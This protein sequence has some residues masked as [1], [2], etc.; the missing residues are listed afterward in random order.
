VTRQGA[1]AVVLTFARRGEQD[2]IR[3]A[4]DE[5]SRRAGAAAF[6]AVATPASLP[7]LAEVGL[8]DTVVFGDGSGVRRVLAG[9]RSRRPGRAVVVYSSGRMSAHLKLEFVALASGARMTYRCAPGGRVE[10]V[11]RLGLAWSVARKCLRA[12]GC[13]AAG[14]IVCLLAW[15]WLRGAQA[16]A[17]GRYARRA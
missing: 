9:V 6:V 7:V 1:T 10:V 8:R 5:V 12:A 15:A 13:L 11:G 16:L 4:V 2:V 14:A 17:G 3:A